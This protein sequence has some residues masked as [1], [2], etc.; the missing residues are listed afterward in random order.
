MLVVDDEVGIL[1]MLKM[2]LE[3][4]NYEVLTTATAEE[5]LRLVKRNTP[6][7]ILADIL[8]PHMSGFELFEHLQSQEEFKKIPFIFLTAL[9]NK[10]NMEKGLQMG[11]LDYIVKPFDEKKLLSKVN[12]ILK[13]G[14]E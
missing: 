5:G 1:N 11:A 6:D 9:S 14:E 8:M 3:F 4:S 12:Q 13:P 10:K 2:F 7:L